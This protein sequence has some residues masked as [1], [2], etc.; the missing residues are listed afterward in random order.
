[1]NQ[2]YGKNKSEMNIKKNYAAPNFSVVRL[3][4]VDVIQISYDDFN[5]RAINN[6]TGWSRSF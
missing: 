2:E 6:I 3:E 4:M 1:M 5:G